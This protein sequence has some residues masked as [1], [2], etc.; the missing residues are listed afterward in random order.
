VTIRWM[1]FWAGMMRSSVGRDRLLGEGWIVGQPAGAWQPPTDIYEDDDGIVIRVEA[2]GMRSGDFSISLAGRN[3]IVAGART[4]SVPKR[5][6][7]QMEIPFGE[8]RAEIRLPWVVEPGSVEAAYVD[9]FLLVRLLRPGVQRL[10][11]VE[12]AQEEDG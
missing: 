6:Y 12:S 2:A 9:G 10:A 11:V 5:A 7:H 1:G 4:D 8:F 3:L